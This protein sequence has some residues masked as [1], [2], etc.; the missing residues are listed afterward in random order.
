MIDLAAGQVHSASLSINEYSDV[1]GSRAIF[2]HIVFRKAAW[3]SAEVFALRQGV[4]QQTKNQ[5]MQR[6]LLQWAQAIIALLLM[7]RS[8][9]S[10]RPC[11]SEV[12]IIDPEIS[13]SRCNICQFTSFSLLKQALC[14]GSLSLFSGFVFAL[15]V[16]IF[17]DVCSVSTSH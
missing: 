2:V 7:L 9:V 10:H 8:L 1:E 15:C 4:F 14:G 6:E 13:C 12:L 11:V 3:L 5:P 16:L 17:F